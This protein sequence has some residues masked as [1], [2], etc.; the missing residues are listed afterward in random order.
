MC[1]VYLLHS[2]F[3]ATIKTSV[4]KYGNSAELMDL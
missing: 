3:L 2:P 1:K 4:K